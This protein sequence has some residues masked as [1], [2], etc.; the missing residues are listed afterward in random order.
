MADVYSTYDAKA[1]FSE[2]IRKVRA[3]RRIVVLHRGRPVAEI[4]PI[5]EQART[6]AES[7]QRLEDEGAVVRSPA[8]AAERRAL[9]RRRGALGRFLAERD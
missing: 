7:L 3:G 6:L 8:A 4:A 2:V 9:V 5:G 1:R